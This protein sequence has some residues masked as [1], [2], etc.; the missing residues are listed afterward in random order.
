MLCKNFTELLPEQTPKRVKL[1]VL[2]LLQRTPAGRRWLT[3][4]CSGRR[5][6]RWPTSAAMHP[7]P[8]N[9]SPAVA[10][11]RSYSS[12]THPI[13][14]SRHVPFLP[15]QSCDHAGTARCKYRVPCPRLT[16]SCLDRDKSNKGFDSGSLQVQLVCVRTLPC[17][18]KEFVKILMKLCSD[19]A[20]S[21]NTEI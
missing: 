6:R 19:S 9:S 17:G 11:P 1:H 8:N 7:W 2:V 14:K 4:S 5:R 3:R 16:V 15:D 12:L 20:Y 10:C 21:E 18:R 13:E